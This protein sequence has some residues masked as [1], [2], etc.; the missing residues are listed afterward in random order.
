MTPTDSDA[1]DVLYRAAV[2]DLLGVLAYG[3]LTAFER[4]AADAAL[5]PAIEDQAAMAGLAATQYDHFV[6]LRDRIQQMGAD[7]VAA[8]TPFRPAIDAFHTLTKPHDWL[9][10]LIK[11]YVG[12][13]ITADFYL[14]IAEHLDPETKALVVRMVQWYKQYRAILESDV[15]HLRR[16]DGQRLDFVLHANP[17]TSPR[18]MLVAYNPTD[19]VLRETV[20]V[21]LYYAGITKSTRYREKEGKFK[22]LTVAKQVATIVVEVPAHGWTYYS[23]E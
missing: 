9:E 6:V 5:A 14:E 11:A 13:G 23:V 15:V 1:P 16:A 17:K 3:E 2:V 19:Q 22:R 21:P 4:M 12:D 18:A 7:A 20:R 8:M 10:G